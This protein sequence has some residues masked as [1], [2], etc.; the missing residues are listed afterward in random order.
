MY[1]SRGALSLLWLGDSATRHAAPRSL[2][3]ERPM[4][5]SK[6]QPLEDR[7][8]AFFWLNDH[9]GKVVDVTLEAGGG[10]LTVTVLSI[11]GKLS[12]WREHEA[13]QEFPALDP[14][15]IHDDIIGLYDIG[16]AFLDLTRLPFGRSDHRW[17]IGI[18]QMTVSLG[19]EMMLRVAVS[20]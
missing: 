2:Q 18:E 13:G 15:E 8:K 19:P 17:V 16:G 3:I 6:S 20:E 5:A 1:L 4:S 10:D 14:A 11:E 7:D 12:H 9:C